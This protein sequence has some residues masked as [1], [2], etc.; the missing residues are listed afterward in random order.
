MD[1]F[2]RVKGGARYLKA[3][4]SGGQNGR[5]PRRHYRLGRKEKSLKKSSKYLRTVLA[6]LRFKCYKINPNKRSSMI[7]EPLLLALPR[8]TKGKGKAAG[9]STKKVWLFC[10]EPRKKKTAKL[11]AKLRFA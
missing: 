5:Y 11:A 7:V 8:F 2:V 9:N 1:T 6:C 10:W 4:V 3:I